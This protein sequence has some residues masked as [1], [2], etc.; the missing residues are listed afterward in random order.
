MI[1]QI[2][3]EVGQFVNSAPRIAA[4]IQNFMLELQTKVGI[5]L[6]IQDMLSKIVSADNFEK[7]GQTLLHNLTNAG[8]FLTKFLIG[9]LLSYIFVMERRKILTFLQKLREGNFAFLYYE[10]A[11]IA[12]K[13]VYGFGVIFKAQSIIALVNAI[14]TTLGLFVISIIHLNQGAH[15]MFPFIFTLSLIVLIFGFIPVFG[16][17]LSGV[18]IVLIALGYG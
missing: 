11:N 9:L 16:T 7:L 13:M 10:Y 5:D 18:P 2:V 8:A 17:F 4:T 15:H 14:L 6:G 3:R 1:P 12:K